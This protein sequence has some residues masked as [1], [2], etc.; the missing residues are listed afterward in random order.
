M[1]S[2]QEKP[3][4]SPIPFEI[5][6]FYPRLNK[7]LKVIGESSSPVPPRRQRC[8]CGVNLSLNI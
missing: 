1:H 3:K 4:F 6:P 2:A 5:D 7:V 8:N